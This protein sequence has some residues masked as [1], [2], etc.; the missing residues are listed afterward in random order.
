MRAPQ[1]SAA[2]LRAFRLGFLALCIGAIAVLLFAGLH[3]DASRWAFANRCDGRDAMTYYF[4]A[5]ASLQDISPYDLQTISARFHVD[6][7]FVYPLFVLPLFY[8]LLAFEPDTALLVLALLRLVCLG[9]VLTLW[10]RLLPVG[11]RSQLLFLPVGLGAAAVHDLCSANVVAFE[12]LAL[13]LG[14]GALW[15]GSAGRFAGWI[16]VAALPKLLWLALLPLA[17]RHGRKAWRVVVLVLGVAAALFAVWIAVWPESFGQWFAHARMTAT[18]RYNM[19]TLLRSIVAMLGGDVTGDYVGRIE[20]W[21]YGLWIGLVGLVLLRAVRRGVGLRS[22]TLLALASLLAVWPGNLSYSWLPLLP[23][24]PVVAFFLA[25]NGMTAAAL[26]LA[27]LCLWPQ[28]LLDWT[29]PGN[30]MGQGAFVAVAALW[31]SLAVIVA[32]WPAAFEAW[33]GGQAPAAD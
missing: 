8:P 23:L 2:P 21:G 18:F 14:I 22:L 6:A 4:A 13:W 3:D 30:V 26:M 24:V 27:A 32:R 15:R 29:G 5:L 10:A 28:P 33:L 1:A 12:T 16:G 20:A 19:F 31:A 9:G 17:L 7:L 25:A 11:W